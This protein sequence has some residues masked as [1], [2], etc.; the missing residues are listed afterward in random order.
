MVST[1][2]AHA[3]AGGICGLHTHFPNFITTQDCYD[4]DRVSTAAVDNLLASAEASTEKTAWYAYLDG[5]ADFLNELVDAGGTKIPM[6][7]RFFHEMNGWHNY[8]IND[9]ENGAAQIETRTITS[10]NGSG[11]NL[12]AV[13]AARPAPAALNFSLTAGTYVQIT[14]ASAGY[15]G[16][17]RVSSCTPTGDTEGVAA[18]LVLVKS[19]GTA[20]TA[21]AAGVPGVIYRTDGFWWAGR[22]RAVNLMQLFREAVRYLRHIKGVR[23]ALY[24]A[25]LYPHDQ[26]GV[27]WSSK[28]T[29]VD[30]I[31]RTFAYDNWYAGETNTDLAGMDYY[32][33]ATGAVADCQSDATIQASV[34][35]IKEAV[36][37]PFFMCEFGA[38]VNGLGDTQV[39][40]WNTAFGGVKNF[41]VAAM[42]I[43]D[44]TFFPESTDPAGPSFAAMLA[45]PK[46][47]TLAKFNRGW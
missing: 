18:T 8:L 25:P 44:E 17:Y 2:Q 10:L 5:I 43:W 28:E 7:V 35:R 16:G 26:H 1:I 36:P 27:H 46:C 29:N 41:G 39:G 30:S 31:G 38:T 34:R 45:D 13:L 4:R 33:F 19:N 15:N 11:T 22:D 12:T 14:G 9:D 6:A 32:H 37:K 47:I 3:N 40:F 20:V 23:N 21:G 42:L 24:Y